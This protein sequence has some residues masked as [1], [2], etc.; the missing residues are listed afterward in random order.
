MNEMPGT[1]KDP[2][3]EVTLTEGQVESL[4]QRMFEAGWRKSR[5]YPNHSQCEL[6]I[7]WAVVNGDQNHLLPFPSNYRP[8]P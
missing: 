2:D 3:R 8:L 6:T 4:M 5:H 1:P 7:E